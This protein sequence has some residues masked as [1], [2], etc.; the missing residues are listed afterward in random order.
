[1]GRPDIQTMMSRIPGVAETYFQPPENVKLRFPCILYSL[2]GDKPV[3]ADNFI[4]KNKK[5]YTVTVMDKDPK[6]RIAEWVRR[7][8]YCKFDR[9]FQKD[10]MNHFVYTLYY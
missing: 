5:K 7:L 8:P 10:N 4:Y 2:S 3:Y 1:M 6:S 9:A